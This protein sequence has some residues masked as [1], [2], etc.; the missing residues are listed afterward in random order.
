MNKPNELMKFDL[1]QGEKICLAPV[2]MEHDPEIISL[3][4]HDSSYLRALGPALAQPVPP[5]KV[6]KM[7]EELEKDSDKSGNLYHFTIRTLDGDRLIGTAQIKW[8]EWSTGS[9]WANLGIGS[10]DDRGKG[11]GTEAFHK[12]LRYAFHEL[13][14]YRLTAMVPGYNE[15]ARRFIQ[16]FGFTEDA[17][18]REA[19]H[20]YG[21]HWDLL[22]CGLLRDE[23]LQ[24]SGSIGGSK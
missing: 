7:L 23:W 16:R 18:Q 21:R 3:W 2:D 6:K 8:I 13:N 9:G 11:Y 15:G 20:C 12:L 17:C 19:L 22:L 14:L 4:S 10:P 24:A 1:F 5:S